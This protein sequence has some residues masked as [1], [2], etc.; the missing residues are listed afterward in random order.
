MAMRSVLAMA[1][2][3]GACGSQ[4]NPDACC[5]DAADCATK[6]LPDGSMCTGGLICRGN[7]CVAE[8]CTTSADCE[9][10]A[11]FCPSLGLCAAT[12]DTDAE[13]P[14]FGGNPIDQFCSNGGCVQC[15]DGSDCAMDAPICDAGACRGC[16]ADS[17]CASGL[18]GSAGACVDAASIVYLDPAGLDGGDCGQAAP[19]KTI[20]FAMS[21]TSATRTTIVMGTGQYVEAVHLAPG[22]GLAADLEIRGSGAVVTTPF[23]QDTSSFVIDSGFTNVRIDGLT[24]TNQEGNA[25]MS[26][27]PLEL[28]SVT[29]SGGFYCILAQA[30]LTAYDVSVSQ[31]GNG[32]DV[33]GQLTADGLRI[34]GSGGMST[35][36]RVETGAVVLVNNLVV[37]KAEFHCIEL[38][39]LTHGTISFATVADCGSQQ[40]AAP[41]AVDC[42]DSSVTLVSSIIWAP[43]AYSEVSACSLSKSIV[44][45]NAVTGIPFTDPMFVNFASGDLSLSSSSPA[46]D[47]VPTGPATDIIGTPRPQGAHFDIGAYEYK[48]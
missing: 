27:S 43:G 3:V 32:V 46:I 10:G 48:P 19:C 6:G 31:C 45:P 16:A 14:G 24:L 13:C 5:T 22:A 1:L 35:G 12:C 33:Y 15:R 8:D 4:V 17:E 18:C 30:G 21:K 20:T 41:L 28:H 36:L 44:G 39:S 47:M 42:I 9:A 40:T 29:S 23:H 38:T 7:T 34:E 11:P 2:L 37:N 26:G 25:L